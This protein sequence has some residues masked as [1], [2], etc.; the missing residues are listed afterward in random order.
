M[1]SYL[2]EILGSLEGVTV[3]GFSLTDQREGLTHYYPEARDS[4][5][6]HDWSAERALLGQLMGLQADGNTR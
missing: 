5:V 1:L 4:A 2:H 3:A 6:P